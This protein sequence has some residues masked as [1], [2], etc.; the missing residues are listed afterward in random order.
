MT[1]ILPASR[2]V[3]PGHPYPHQLDGTEVERNTE[4]P[5]WADGL[6]CFSETSL[7]CTKLRIHIEGFWN[8]TNGAYDCM[9]STN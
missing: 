2:Q 5:L 4:S 8:G 3:G 7:N 6:F 9:T 1:L